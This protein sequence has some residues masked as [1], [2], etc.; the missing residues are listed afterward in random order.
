MR[1]ERRIAEVMGKICD[2]VAQALYRYCEVAGQIAST[3][4]PGLFMRESFL[5]A[6]VLDRLGNGLTMTLETNYRD[7]E[8]FCGL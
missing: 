3:Y 8:D 5:A 2:T 7:L 6:F 1:R 4:T